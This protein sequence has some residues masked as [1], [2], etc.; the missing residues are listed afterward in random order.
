MSEYTKFMFDNFVLEDDNRPTSVLAEAP[1][2][3]E[4]PSTDTAIQAPIDDAHI[5]E[6][7]VEP[8]PEPEPVPEP[9]PEPIEVEP[10]PVE[11][12]FS[13]AEVA[14]KVQAAETEAYQKGLD[15]AKQSEEAAANALLLKID[16][17]ISQVLADNEQA[18]Q[19]LSQEFRTMAQQMLATLVPTLQAEQASNIIEKFLEDNFK[20]F[21]HEVKLSFYF[22]PAII[23]QAQAILGRLAHKNDFEGKITLHKDSSLEIGDCRVEWADGGV[24]YSNE[25]MRRA[26]EELLYTDKE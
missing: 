2:E 18:R 15:E 5:I 16:A 14:Q 11:P 25:G 7:E 17:A 13:E 6:A 26:A 20:N 22:N 24:E 1:E 23:M 12:T 9:E 19:A 4:L 8:E 10:E 3:I 21:S